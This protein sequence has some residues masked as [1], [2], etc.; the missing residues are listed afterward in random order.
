MDNTET[1]IKTALNLKPQERLLVIESLLSSIDNPDKEL[2]E[3]W[4]R[5]AEKR[6]LAYK[7]GRLETHTLQEVFGEK[8]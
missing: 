3:I 2:D 4:A 5:E 8:L 6:L 1:I 7:K